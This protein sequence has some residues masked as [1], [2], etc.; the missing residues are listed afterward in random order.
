MQTLG[1]AVVTSTEHP[2]ETHS[3]QNALG[4]HFPGSFPSELFIDH[5]IQI[6]HP[7]GF[8]P[9]NTMACAS[10]CRDEMTRP[11]IN[12]LNKSWHSL[13]NFSSLAGMLY[14]GV[15]GFK[16]AH[17]HAPNLDGKERYIYFAFPHIG[18]DEYGVPGNCRRPGRHEMSHACGALLNVM[19]D[20]SQGSVEPDLNQDDLEQSLLKKR[21]FRKLGQGEV[22][23]LV[24]LT[25]IAQNIIREDLE[26]MIQLTVEQTSIAYA[27]FSGI[28]IHGPHNQTWIW[29]DTA[30]A[31]VNG[32]R[33]DL[34]I[35]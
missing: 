28:Q 23:D 13:F 18:I 11:F 7:L 21:L 1:D 12:S 22:P 26:R 10:L 5:S 25:K 9:D 31:V 29:P 32:I 16:A 2:L 3:F 17:Q 8:G 30:Y 6:L 35:C 19:Q 24:S 4:L 14:L 15:T 20:F 27:V 34:D 33:E